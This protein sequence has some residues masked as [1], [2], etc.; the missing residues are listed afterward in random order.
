MKK[1][2]TLVFLLVL[3]SFSCQNK[4]GQQIENKEAEEKLNQ[5][6]RKL[7]LREKVGQL[8]C[9]QF[10]YN[11]M[12]EYGDGSLKGFLEKYPVGSIFMANWAL[13]GLKGKDSIKSQYVNIVTELDKASKYP[14]LFS[15]DF[16]T[17]LGFAVEG[18]TQM[19][20]EMGLGAANSEKLASNYGE[21]IAREARSCGINW[22]LNPVADLNLNPFNFI[23]NV[24]SLG[25]DPELSVKLLP[26]QIKSMQEH[27]VAATAKHFPG[28][29]TDFINQHFSTST[30]QL[31][32]ENW[33][34]TY[35]KVF[36]KLI[37]SDVMAIMP[38]HITLPSFQKVKK[39]GEYLPATLSHEL[40][41]DLLKTDMGFNGVVVSD[42]L[43]MAGM[44]NYYNGQI[45]TEVECFKAG[46]DVL[47]W[48]QLSIIDTIEARVLRGDI[49]IARLE[50]AVSRVWN[51]KKKLGLFESDYQ[52]ILP[53]SETTILKHHE[54]AYE[55]AK[56]SLTLISSPSNQPILNS[57]DH[58]I[59]LV[60]VVQ[61]YKSELFN[62]LCK[63]LE[64]RGYELE[65]RRDLSYFKAGSELPDINDEFDKI[66]FAYY[67]SPGSP[68]GELSL[69][70]DEALTMW[71]ANMFTPE[72]VISIGFGDPY[73]NILYL[74]R[75]HCRINCYNI[76]EGTQ[77]A[78]A[79]ALVGEYHFSGKS[80]VSYPSNFSY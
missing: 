26:N 24:R 19:V 2:P 11:E 38:G 73:K 51:L 56:Q 30:N 43:N 20:A 52:A 75:S 48:P 18:Y 42:A 57:S 16:E 72:K 49:D 27:G 74:R 35:G 45:E 33:W 40:M 5:G 54:M 53:I 8:V 80:P 7:S 64:R 61:E 21:I 78:L 60:E 29:G 14:L 46:A 32:W 66:I 15:E 77:K 67:S 50:D 58:K 63:E 12:L 79:G 70:G 9:Y 34:K 1:L 44:A 28:D 17:G 22:L 10:N 41:T 25:K 39:N 3:L 37:D 71:S 4:P 55:I 23:T 69:N 36:Q 59:L 31:S 65:V 76:D 13:E 68:W 6:W 47:L 62:V